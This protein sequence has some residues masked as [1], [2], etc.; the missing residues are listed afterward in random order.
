M[1]FRHQNLIK[2][3]IEEPVSELEPEINKNKKPH[4]IY[5]HRGI[6]HWKKHRA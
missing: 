2:M 1:K 5:A 3:H 4:L 6:S